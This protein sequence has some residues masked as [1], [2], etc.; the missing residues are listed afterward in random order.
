[1][2]HVYVPIHMFR[3]MHQPESS[4]HLCLYCCKSN[5]KESSRFPDRKSGNSRRRAVALLGPE[6]DEFELG[7]PW[8]TFMGLMS[9]HHVGCLPTKVHSRN[10]NRQVSMVFIRIRR[11]PS[12]Q[13]RTRN[14]HGLHRFACH[15]GQQS[16]AFRTNP[17]SDSWK[18]CPTTR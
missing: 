9:T 16:P 17:S 15:F 18:V 10:L 13:S 6:R 12:K 1:M 5:P 11:K 7:T 3:S 8:W 2:R 14:C 4:M